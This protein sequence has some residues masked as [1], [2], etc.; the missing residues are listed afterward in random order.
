MRAFLLALFLMALGVSEGHAS[1]YRLLV[2]DGHP[3][4]WG[5]GRF[6]AGISLSYSF[7][8]EPVAFPNAINCKTMVPVAALLERSAIAADAFEA[9]VRGAFREWERVANLRFTYVADPAAADILIGAQAQPQGIAFAN[10]QHDRSA[11]GSIAPI[12]RA[13][14]C[15]NPLLSWEAGLD[16]DRKTFSVG[17][18]TAHEIGHTI[19]LDHPGRTGQLMGYRYAEE[20]PGLQPGDVMGAVKLYGRAPIS[21]R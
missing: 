20:V 6:G 10:V 16:G 1:A 14:I 12:T 9:A 2:L 7:V 17:Q 13:S 18:I 5:E 19:G 8:R 4:K 21:A 15:Y 3:V 11:T